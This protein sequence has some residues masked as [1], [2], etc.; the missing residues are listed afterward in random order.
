M[1]SK[2]IHCPVCSGT[3]SVYTNYGKVT[4]LN[5]KGRGFINVS[6]DEFNRIEEKRVKDLI[7]SKRLDKH[8]QL[9]AEQQEK[10]AALSEKSR[11]A[12]SEE[13]GGL[14]VLLICLA[15]AIIGLV[16]GFLRHDGGL[17][18]GFFMQALFIISAI[19][20]VITL[21]QL[22]SPRTDDDS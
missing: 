5:C 12:K 8:Y 1:A 20:G 13:Q 6:L 11:N 9:E 7:E 21:I 15:G 19:G 22:A 16:F 10:Q 4:C 3:R 2:A 17:F 14:I 18:T